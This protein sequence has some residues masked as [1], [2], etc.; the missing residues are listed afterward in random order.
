M[1]NG[2]NPRS[3]TRRSG[4]A[5]FQM[6]TT[7]TSNVA[8]TLAALEVGLKEK[9]ARSGARA[10]ITVFYN[11]MRRLVPVDEGTLHDSI[12]TYH[13]D[14][15]GK[16]IQRYYA[17]PNKRKAPHWHNVEYGHWRVNVI[18]KGDNGKWI[19]TKERL[20]APVWVP[21][22]P[23]TR[24][25]YDGNKTQAASAVKMRMTERYQELVNSL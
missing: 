17:G 10:G 11:A 19:F 13:D 4:P 20:P 6:E 25:A 3:R 1:A 8:E 14:N 2:R 23:Y 16:Y 15:A 7:V 5:S 12:Y 9:V 24:P 22:R 18:R 21:G